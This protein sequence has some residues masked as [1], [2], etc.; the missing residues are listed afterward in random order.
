M[1]T[2]HKTKKA[3]KVTLQ[4]ATGATY[5]EL[6]Q[7][8]TEAVLKHQQD[9]FLAFHYTVKFQSGFPK[10]VLIEKTETSNIYKVKSR[11][12]LDFLFDIGQSEY[13]AKMLSANREIYERLATDIEK[14]YNLNIGE[15]L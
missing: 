15:D 10:G 1:V 14:E 13:N 12:L 2:R 6:Q 8:A 3:V 4:G 7:V 5:Q 9:V 11:K